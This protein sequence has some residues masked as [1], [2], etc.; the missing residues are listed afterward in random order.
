MKRKYLLLLTTLFVVPLMSSCKKKI[1]SADDPTKANLHV[2]VFGGGIGGAWLEEAAVRFE[3]KFKDSTNFQQGR[4]GVKVHVKATRDYYAPDFVDSNFDKDIYFTEDMDYI[5]FINKGKVL[6]MTDVMTTPL[7]AYGESKSILDKINEVEWTNDEEKTNKTAMV[8]DNFL[9]RNGKYY[10]IPYYDSFY[11]FV[12]NKTLFQKKGLYIKEGDGIK[13][14]N[15]LSERSKGPDNVAG[16]Y[17]D[18][19]PT[20]YEEFGKLMDRMVAL[21][22]T[23]FLTSD[24]GREYVDNTLSNFWANYEGYDQMKINYNFNGTMKNHVQ[25]INDGVVTTN[26]VAITT[27]NGYELQ[28]SAGKYQA[29]NFLENYMLKDSKYH[30]NVDTH[31]NAQYMYVFGSNNKNY[32]MIIEGSW[33]ENEAGQQN[34]WKK[35]ADNGD[36]RDEYALMPIPFVDKAH[37]EKMNYKQTRFS[38]SAS[39]GF[40]SSNSSQVALAKEFM[41]FLHTDAELA[42]FTKSTSMTRPLAYNVS[43]EFY[44]SLTSYGKSLVD[45]KKSIDIV[46][47]YGNTKLAINNYDDFKHKGWSWR[48]RIDSSTLFGPWQWRTTSGHTRA[49]VT[50]FNGLYDYFSLNWSNFLDKAR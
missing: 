30:E 42:N 39:Y 36:E 3:E 9:N 8:Y 4:T 40:I 14:T 19:L 35:I 5:S 37:A 24:A 27:Q 15:N 18:G 11:G 29:L 6:D 31:L 25:S 47:P 23:P 46:Y 38:L 26:E 12:Y 2:G 32:G 45:I 49:D 21:N 10:A 43:D 28:K 44:N 50:Y 22:I 16:T 41:R 20:T 13:F 48:S 17:D 7:T 34:V 33:W 1:I